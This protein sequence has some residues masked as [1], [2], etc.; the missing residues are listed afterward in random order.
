MIIIFDTNI[1]CQDYYFESPNFKILFEW[2]ETIKTKG[3]NKVKYD[4][5]RNSIA[6]EY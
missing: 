5:K 3:K 1:I 2:R 4:Q 6:V